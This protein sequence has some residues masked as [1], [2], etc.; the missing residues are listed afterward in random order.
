MIITLEL[1]GIVVT[2][3]SVAVGIVLWV[4]G[5][6]NKRDLEIKLLKSDNSERVSKV[7]EELSEYKL[8]V[9]ENFATKGGVSESFNQVLN[10]IER[11]S[12]RIDKIMS[13]SRGGDKDNL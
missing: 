11:L 3:I 5:Q 9:S 7:R 12:S 6:F 4:L 13:V 1:V 8:Y 10:S 2:S